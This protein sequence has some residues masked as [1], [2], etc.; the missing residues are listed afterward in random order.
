MPILFTHLLFG[1]AFLGAIALFYRRHLTHPA[2]YVLGALFFLLPDLDHLLYW[3]PSMWGLIFPSTLEDL[4]REI[5]VPRLPSLLHNWIFP[6]SIVSLT[7]LG[8]H[9]GWR[10]WKYL[11]ILAAG[12]AVHLL[13]DG[14]LLV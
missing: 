6:I 8:L 9:Y 12:W 3:D 14:V 13:L 5:F 4:L 2:V 10:E 7:A 1:A 11:A